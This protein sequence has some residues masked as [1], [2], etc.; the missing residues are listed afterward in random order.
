[1]TAI[2]MFKPNVRLAKLAVE[3]GGIR[4]GDAVRRAGE[5]L[6]TIRA[7]SLT[8]IDQFIDSL[9]RWVASKSGEDVGAN[10]KTAKE[11]FGLAGTY[12]LAELSLAAHS[13]CEMLAHGKVAAHSVPWAHVKVHVD[14]MKKLRQP[15]LDGDVNARKAIIEGLR[16]VSARV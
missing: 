15:A 4:V 2:R 7:S 10:Y 9:D 16:M 8:A 11:V 12:G 3:P 5:N 13:L 6:N 14:A 1:M